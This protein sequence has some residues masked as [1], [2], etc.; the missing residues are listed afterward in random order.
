MTTAS[1]DRIRELSRS[2]SRGGHG[3]GGGESMWDIKPSSLIGRSPRH[4]NSHDRH[5]EITVD[6]CPHLWASPATH[7]NKLVII[8]EGSGY[9]EM[10]CLHLCG[11][12]SSLQRRGRGHNSSREY[13]REDEEEGREEQ[14]GGLKS[15]SYNLRSR[16]PL[17]HPTTLVAGKDKNLA[18]LCFGVN[19]RHGEKVFL[20]SNNS[21]L[22][23]MD[24]PAKALAF[25]TERE[26][27]DSIIGARTDAIFLRGLNNS[28]VPYA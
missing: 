22:R 20:M 3:H 14:E 27:V 1:E 18:V 23:Q 25:E 9:F 8:V 7:F 13:G 2:C 17:G 24:E 5:Y 4:S 6:D 11:G 28:R 21:A 10:A 12:R 26:K 16:I 19:A 15:R